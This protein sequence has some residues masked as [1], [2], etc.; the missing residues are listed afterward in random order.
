ME[1]GSGSR[2]A[3]PSLAEGSKHGND[4]W[5][6]GKCPGN[7]GSE[8]GSRS[9]QRAIKITVTRSL[10]GNFQRRTSEV[11]G[12][13]TQ[14]GWSVVTSNQVAVSKGSALLNVDDENKRIGCRK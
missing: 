4:D 12:L 9:C 7:L 11:R 13:M 14:D 5:T 2:W 1:G 6:S 3:V 8:D 10:A